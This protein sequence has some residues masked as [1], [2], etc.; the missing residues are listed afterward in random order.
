M[1]PWKSTE[2][3]HNHIIQVSLLANSFTEAHTAVTKLR[4]GS[5]GEILGNWL[6][7]FLGASRLCSLFDNY[8]IPQIFWY[9]NH[10]EFVH[11]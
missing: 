4:I 8:A 5:E 9:Q 11:D 10:C 2:K 1:I 7:I 3:A 6:L